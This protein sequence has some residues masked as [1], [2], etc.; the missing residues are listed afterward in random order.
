M[1]AVSERVFRIQAPYDGNAVHLY[2]VRGAKLALID[3]GASDSPSAAVEPALRE[4]GLHWSDLDFLLNTHGHADHAGGNGELRVF[5][6]QVAVA[7]HPADKDLLGG[8]EAHLRSPVDAAAAM[9]LMG[10][11]D[12]VHE[13]EA[14]LRRVVGRSTGVDRELADG[15]VVDLGDDV[16]LNVVHT[17]G[18]TSG[19]VCYYWESGATVFSGDAVQGHG[20]RAGMAPIYHD[21]CYLDS[22][23]RIGEL[24]ADV[25]CMGHTFG[26]SGVLNDPVRHGTDIG[27]TLDASRRA[28]A[29]IDHAASTALEQL[30][31]HVSFLELA[32]A[33]FRELVY[34]LPLVFDRRTLVPPA[35]ARAIR[36]HLEAQG[37]RAPSP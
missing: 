25:L 9:R 16:R 5:A 13:R 19:S 8:P 2:L 1:P 24:G 12:M 34:D 14:V 23:T 7:I 29:A 22:L 32:Q 4:L 6:P 26:W 28:S 27:L 33:A 18:H 31:P 17:P 35:V 11:E 36:A 15:D 3:S 20:W 37:W 21:V 30:G 10:R